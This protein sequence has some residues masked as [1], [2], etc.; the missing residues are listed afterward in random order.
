[1]STNLITASP[2]TTTQ[3]ATR[4]MAKH[5]IRRIPIVE[6]GKLVGIVALGD[7]E[8]RDL[9]DQQ[10]LSEISETSESQIQH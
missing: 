7:L 5:Q 2:E 3:E 4:L 10:A 8:V 9:T 6:K 1:M